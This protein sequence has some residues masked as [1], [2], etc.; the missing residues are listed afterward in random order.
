MK[1]QGK[2]NSGLSGSVP[3]L[4][5]FISQS[6]YRW[7][8]A[9]GHLPLSGLLLGRALSFS[10]PLPLL[11]SNSVLISVTRSTE[12]AELRPTGRKQGS[13]SPCFCWAFFFPFHFRISKLCWKVLLFFLII[14]TANQL[15]KNET[16]RPRW[17]VPLRKCFFLFC[18]F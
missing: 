3:D 6:S 10:P 11:I 9:C 7:L 12:A 17:L 13:A 18:F 1:R 5:L 2:S 14:K 16:F 15:V 4:Q 8:K